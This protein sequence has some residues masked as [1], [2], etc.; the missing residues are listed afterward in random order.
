MVIDLADRFGQIS[1]LF[2]LGIAPDL[3][4]EYKAAADAK[5]GSDPTTAVTAVLIDAYR[6]WAKSAEGPAV[7][8]LSLSVIDYLAMSTKAAEDEIPRLFER[9]RDAAITNN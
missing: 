3:D 5:V 1:M 8:E 7:R 9:L 6:R 2:R 4:D